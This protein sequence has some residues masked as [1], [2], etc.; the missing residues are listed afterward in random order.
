MCYRFHSFCF[1]S[2]PAGTIVMIGLVTAMQFK[3]MFFHHQWA[4]PQVHSMMFSFYGMFLYFMLIAVAVD[5]YWNVAIETYNLPITWLWGILVVPFTAVFIDWFAYFTRYVFFPTREMIFR[6]MEKQ[7]STSSSPPSQLC[8]T[9]K[10][11]I[12]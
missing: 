1:R 9:L 7:V 6:E 3:V 12:C 10:F 2:S 5:D 8:M 11:R 4:W